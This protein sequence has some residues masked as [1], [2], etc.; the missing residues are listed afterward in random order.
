MQRSL[1]STGGRPKSDALFAKITAIR[2]SHTVP[3]YQGFHGGYSGG[4]GGVLGFDISVVSVGRYQPFE[5]TYCL[6]LQC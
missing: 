6:R 3:V 4:D 5:G 1:V 2:L